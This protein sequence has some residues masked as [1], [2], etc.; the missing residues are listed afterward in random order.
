MSS[1]SKVGILAAEYPRFQR[2]PDL[3]WVSRGLRR[4]RDAYP[5]DSRFKI[6]APL[7]SELRGHRRGSRAGNGKPGASEVVAGLEN[8]PCIRRR[9]DAERNEVVKLRPLP[10]EKK[11]LSCN[12]GP[13]R[14]PTQVDEER[15]LRPAGEAL[16]RN[17]AK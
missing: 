16:L 4:G 7:L 5:M 1:E 3:L 12:K 2:V 8:P 6:P 9:R 14:K 13:Y 15:I 10:V 11:P 17:S